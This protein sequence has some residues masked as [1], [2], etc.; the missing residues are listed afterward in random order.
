MDT[1]DANR[2]DPQDHRAR[3]GPPRRFLAFAALVLLGSITVVLCGL[4][5]FTFRSNPRVYAVALGDL[6]EDGD[7]DAFYVNGESEAPQAS[8]FIQPRGARGRMAVLG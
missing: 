8:G 4:I 3:T 2:L 1:I 7:L 5:F 6:D